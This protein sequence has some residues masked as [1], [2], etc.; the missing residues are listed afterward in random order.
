M[1]YPQHFISKS[2]AFPVV[3]SIC[4]WFFYALD[5]QQPQTPKHKSKQQ[6]NK[7]PKPT[8]ELVLTFTVT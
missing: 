3:A 1:S 7:K 5:K 4:F 8:E 2:S 6:Q